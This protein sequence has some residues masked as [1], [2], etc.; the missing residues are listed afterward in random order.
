MYSKFLLPLTT[1]ILA[2]ALWTSCDDEQTC[3]CIGDP[4]RSVGAIQIVIGS[5]SDTLHFIPGDPASFFVPVTII[6]TDDRGQPF[7]GIKVDVSLANPSFGV[8]E[9]INDALLDTT[10]SLGRVETVFRTYGQEG[11]QVITATAG[12]VSISRVL[13]IT[14]PE[15]PI[16]NLRIYATPAVIVA[17]S[18]ELAQTLITCTIRDAGNRGVPNVIIHPHTNHGTFTAPY[19]TDSTGRTAFLWN[20]YNE[21]GIFSIQAQAGAHSDSVQV[22]VRLREAPFTFEFGATLA[23]DTFLFLPTDSSSYPPGATLV[24]FL[25]DSDHQAMVGVP[26]VVTVSNGAVGH[27]EYPL[28]RYDRTDHDGYAVATFISHLQEGDVTIS[29]CAIGVEREIT[30]HCVEVPDP[31]LFGLVI[32]AASND[33]TL[34]VPVGESDSLQFR[35]YAFDANGNPTSDANNICLGSHVTDGRLF[36]LRPIRHGVSENNYWYFHDNYGTFYLRVFHV[37]LAI[38]VLPSN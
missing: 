3:D 15:A 36:P 28:D 9:F 32:S 20:F 13:V 16:N 38:T 5:P 14:N 26:V 19:P 6:V 29:A 4:P 22:E 24:A 34:Y 12:G 10:N 1:L 35:I 8:I 17:D 27:I 25:V 31:N 11:D 2:T 30:L 33:D 18:N 23:S 7:P 21:F 37:N